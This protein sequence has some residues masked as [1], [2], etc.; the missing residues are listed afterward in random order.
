MIYVHANGSY[1]D[2]DTKIDDAN[3]MPIEMLVKN[4]GEATQVLGID[5]LHIVKSI[6]VY[7]NKKECTE[8][9]GRLGEVCK[10]DD[11]QPPQNICKD[12]GFF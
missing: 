11:A 2:V 4:H 10:M 3:G 5:V 8:N 9:W 7:I 6:S 1:H 12:G